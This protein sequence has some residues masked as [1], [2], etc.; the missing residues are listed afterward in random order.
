LEQLKQDG[1]C[2]PSQHW[3]P[4]FCGSLIEIVIERVIA[5]QAPV[6]V[7]VTL[8]VPLDDAV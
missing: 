6:P 2:V 7:R 4:V 3:R 1:E 8:S 5:P